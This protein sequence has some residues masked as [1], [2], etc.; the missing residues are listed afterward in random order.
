MDWAKLQELVCAM[1]THQF[2]EGG[3]KLDSEDLWIQQHP[4]SGWRENE[5]EPNRSYVKQVDMEQ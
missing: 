2:A 3:K 5:S 4:E 1:P